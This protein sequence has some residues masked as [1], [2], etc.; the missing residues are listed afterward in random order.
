MTGD[1]SG[2]QAAPSPVSKRMLLAVVLV[3][4][5]AG[6][7]WASLTYRHRAAVDFY[8]YWGVGAAKALGGADLSSPYPG[9][10]RYDKVLDGFAASSGDARLQSA[11]QANHGMYRYSLDMNHTPLLYSLFA[12]FPLDYSLSFGVFLALR[13]ALLV[14]A[15]FF[16]APDRESLLPTMALGVVVVLLY[17]PLGADARVGNLNVI[18]LFAMAGLASALAAT[19]QRGGRVLSSAALV[20]GLAFLALLK[21]NL[22]LVA[23][24]LCVSLVARGG[25][26]RSWKAIAAGGLF[27]LMLA[28]VPC[29]YF[30]S[31][32]V[33]LDWIHHFALGDETLSER[34]IWS[35]NFSTSL[36]VSRLGGLSAGTASLTLAVLL[37]LSLVLAMAGRRSF[38]ETAGIA[39]RDPRLLV[40]LAVTATLAVSAIAW[41]HYYVLSLFPVLWLLT[42]RSGP[43][44]SRILGG[45]SLLLSSGLLEEI[46]AV[47]PAL[48]YV[49]ASSWA[50]LWAGLL[51][52]ISTGPLERVSSSQPFA[53]PGPPGDQVSAL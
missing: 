6:A 23:L 18:Q 45:V 47:R 38:Y 37:A 34:G 26:E 7:F 32:A 12:L 43:A 48:P 8:Q 28:S 21:P 27:G 52:L 35:G 53:R 30:K 4:V 36:M 46:P 25:V 14:A 50:P 5:G 13:L 9:I 19:P 24:A 44:A 3:L 49:V 11:N 10:E 20:G 39:L 33:W 17:R 22:I 51:I 40:S 31:W 42:R 2:G 15:L 29:L 16:L 41:F 1:P